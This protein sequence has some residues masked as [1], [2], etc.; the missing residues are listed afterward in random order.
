M[1]ARGCKTYIIAVATNG[2]GD[3]EQGG[4]IRGEDDV[5]DEDVNEAL[6]PFLW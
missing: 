1:K 3:D 6:K 4:K 2:L 5:K